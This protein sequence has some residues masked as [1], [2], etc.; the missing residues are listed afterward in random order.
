MLA[1]R[2]DTTGKTDQQMA[3]HKTKDPQK[4]GYWQKHMH[5]HTCTLPHHAQKH[6][7]AMHTVTG[8]DIHTYNHAHG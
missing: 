1:K 5:T 7:H 8:A 4:K 2:D 6:A 3:G